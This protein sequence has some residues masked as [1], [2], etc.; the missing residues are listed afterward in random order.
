MTFIVKK[1]IFLAAVSTFWAGLCFSSNASLI[2]KAAKSI[3][4]IEQEG[5]KGLGSGFFVTQ[6]GVIVTNFHVLVGAESIMVSTKDG[7]MFRV[8]EVLAVEPRQ[9]LGACP[10]FCVNGVSVHI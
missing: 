8:S 1:A 9:D 2:E 6:D 7:Q 10:N 3:V 4:T 5:G